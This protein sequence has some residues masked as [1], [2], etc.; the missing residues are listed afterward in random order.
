MFRALTGLLVILESLK[1]VRAIIAPTQLVTSFQSPVGIGLTLQDWP[2]LLYKY[3]RFLHDTP[4][5]GPTYAKQLYEASSLIWE[6]PLVCDFFCGK[7]TDVLKVWGK[8][9]QHP[10]MHSPTPGIEPGLTGW[11]PGILAIRTCRRLK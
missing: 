10:K 3:A 5:M 9:E 8:F 6:R 11:K 2:F 1:P 7:A 4:W